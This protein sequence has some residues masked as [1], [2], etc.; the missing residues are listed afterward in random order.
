MGGG[1]GGDTISLISQMKEAVNRGEPRK[2]VFIVYFF[3]LTIRP[4]VLNLKIPHL[5]S[6]QDNEDILSILFD[7]VTSNSFIVIFI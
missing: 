5:K 1:G 7:R 6:Y 2:I 4:I 3:R